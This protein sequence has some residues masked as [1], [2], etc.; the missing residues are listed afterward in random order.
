MLVFGRSTSLEKGKIRTSKTWISTHLPLGGWAPRTWIRGD[1]ITGVPGSSEVLSKQVSPC[2]SLPTP[3]PPLLELHGPKAGDLHP[4]R[5][6]LP[7]KAVLI[8]CKYWLLGSCMLRWKTDW[9]H[10]VSERIFRVL[11]SSCNSSTTVRPYWVRGVSILT[12]A[13][14][15][16]LRRLI[17]IWKQLSDF[18]AR[19]QTHIARHGP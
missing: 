3:E 12:M 17:H 1:R 18:H 7:T 11:G 19:P 2:C 8:I 15:V 4:A 13:M 14:L 5:H 6:W 9:P 16:E 10:R